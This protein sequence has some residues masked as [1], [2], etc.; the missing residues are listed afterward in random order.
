MI[1]PPL[2]DLDGHDFFALYVFALS[3]FTKA[4]AKPEAMKLV[5]TD[6]AVQHI[7]GLDLCVNTSLER[8]TERK[9]VECVTTFSQHIMHKHTTKLSDE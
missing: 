2:E 6:P 9:C 5:F 7:P 4:A 3:N 8:D 1:G